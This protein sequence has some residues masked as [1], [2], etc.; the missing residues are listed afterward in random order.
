MVELVGPKRAG[1]EFRIIVP[2][3]TQVA[4][5]RFRSRTMLGG[6]CLTVTVRR[7][8]TSYV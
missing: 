5:A 6:A 4:V 8:P 3:V 2:E 1:L 7:T